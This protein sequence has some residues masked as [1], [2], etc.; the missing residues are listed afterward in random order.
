MA[1][2]K[3]PSKNSPLPGYGSKSW[4]VITEDR[5]F[6]G[7]ATARDMTAEAGLDVIQQA[8][9]KPLDAEPVSPARECV[10]SEYWTLQSSWR[11]SGMS[12]KTTW[13]E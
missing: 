9:A 8:S 5:G 7:I 12:G 1:S 2:R 3:L 13:D 10:C 4:H 6:T 11:S